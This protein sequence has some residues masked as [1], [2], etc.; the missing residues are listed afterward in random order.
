M[1][2]LFVGADN[3]QFKLEATLPTLSAEKCAYMFTFGHFMHLTYEQTRQR[4][5]AVDLGVRM[6]VLGIHNRLCYLY[7]VY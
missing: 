5:R 4:V 1:H 2:V 7:N 3:F 6:V